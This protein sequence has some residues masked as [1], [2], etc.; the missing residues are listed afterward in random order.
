MNDLKAG[1]PKPV[2]ATEFIFSG[3][4]G[5]KLYLIG[6]QL[7]VD[8][9]GIKWLRAGEPG[10]E[11]TT[12]GRDTTMGVGCYDSFVIGRGQVRD[13]AHGAVCL[14]TDSDIAADY[15]LAAGDGH[16]IFKGATGGVALGFGNVLGKPTGSFGQNSL[17][18]GSA[19]TVCGNAAAAIGT[20]IQN[21][22]D[23]S[24]VVGAGSNA[25]GKLK[26]P[27]EQG[28]VAG[29]A[30]GKTWEIGPSGVTLT[31]PNGTK[32]K[33]S[34]ADDGTVTSKQV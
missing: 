16:L 18:T 6:G 27:T 26:G 14:C 12:I 31:S 1:P 20:G 5:T 9:A 21:D 15:C 28:A 24:L 34:V 3:D 29:G 30:N 10:K 25:T 23:N 22:M 2:T 7:A 19:N 17:A 8:I 32:W 4:N 33:L 13:G 11:G